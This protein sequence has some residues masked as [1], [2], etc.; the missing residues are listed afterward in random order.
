MVDKL[1]ILFELHQDKHIRSHF[2]DL[3][4]VT[5]TI[6]VRCQVERQ[7][8]NHWHGR[9]GTYPVGF[10]IDA[11]WVTNWLLY[12]NCVMRGGVVE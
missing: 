5:L 4:A 6:N 11:R 8:L 10:Q 2:L 7:T 3:Q 9:V 12:S 1:T